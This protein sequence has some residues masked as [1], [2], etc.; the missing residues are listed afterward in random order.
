MSPESQEH[1]A[2]KTARMIAA[3]D[4]DDLRQHRRISQE[5][6]AKRLDIAQSSVSRRLHG[7]DAKVSKVREVVERSCQGPMRMRAQ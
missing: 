4:M 6:L 2:E 1:A 3:M 7:T 5:D